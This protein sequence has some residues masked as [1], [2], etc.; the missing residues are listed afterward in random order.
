MIANAGT[1]R[2]GGQLLVST[3]RGLSSSRAI[4]IPPRST[5]EETLVAP[6]QSSFGAASVLANGT[7]VGVEEVIDSPTGREA[8]ACVGRANSVQ[9]LA[10]GSTKGASDIALAIYDPGATPSVANVSFAT[11]SG[12]VAPLAYQGLPIGAG[13]VAVVDVGHDRRPA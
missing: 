8:A 2:V 5:T 6:A 13:Q 1:S 10:G 12:N 11:S 7:G 9:Y 4:S 3:S